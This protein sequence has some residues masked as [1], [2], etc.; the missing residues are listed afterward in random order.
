[1]FGFG[2]G[3][4]V[5]TLSPAE[6]HDLVA[7]GSVHLVDVRE[8]NEW[9]GVRIAGATHAPLSRLADEAA[10]LPTD[11]PVVFYCAGG[12][13]SAKAIG[14]VRKLGLPHDT[15][16]GGGISAWAQQGLPIER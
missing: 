2:G 16:M 14:L 8:D 7:A 5:K 4:G 3:G 9:E 15:H 13:R 11:K 10:A 1:M 12:V 6:V